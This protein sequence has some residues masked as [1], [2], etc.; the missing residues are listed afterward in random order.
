M[1]ATA[2]WT[3][4]AALERRLRREPDSSARMARI[5]QRGTAPEIEV[6]RIL[7][8]LGLRFRSTN[9]DLPG[10]P[11]IA[12]RAR[13]WAVFVHG[14]YWHAHEGCARATVPKRNR[15]YWLAKFDDNRA[16]DARAVRAL[17]RQGYRVVVVWQC[18]LARPEV[19][20][21]RLGRLLLR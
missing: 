5:R 4:V 19:V 13:H 14:C 8:R 20:A 9:R 3:R 7:H 11:D 15:A 10:S 6:R 2:T 12:N 17:R 1:T 18:H 21:Q 16:R